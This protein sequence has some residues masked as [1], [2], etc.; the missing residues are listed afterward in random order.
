MPYRFSHCPSCDPD[1]RHTTRS[2][3]CPTCGAATRF[4]YWHPNPLELQGARDRVLGLRWSELSPREQRRLRVRMHDCPS[5]FGRGL[6]DPTNPDAALARCSACEGSGLLVLR[7]SEA[8]RIQAVW[9]ADVEPL[10]EIIT[11]WIEGLPKNFEEGFTRPRFDVND[12]DLGPARTFN[13]AVSWGAWVLNCL[14]FPGPQLPDIA[15]GITPRRAP[16]E[17]MLR[18]VGTALNRPEL[19]R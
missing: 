7:D 2:T 1:A 15:E 9:A 6:H 19:Y 18:R 4:R 11:D 5:C 17:A 14:R 10:L 13:T 8:L 12:A 16:W 3:T